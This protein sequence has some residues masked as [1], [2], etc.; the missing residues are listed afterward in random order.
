MITLLSPRLP[1]QKS[2]FLGSGVPY[3]PTELAIFA[4][5]LKEQHEDVFVIDLFGSGVKT[6]EEKEDHYLQGAP[7]TRFIDSDAIRKS[8]AFVLFAISSMSHQE[9]LSITR[10]LKTTANKPLFILEN[11]QAVTAYAIDQ[12]E[13]DYFDA[14]AD[15]LIC[16][17]P[18]WNWPEIRRALF[19]NGS[20]APT[21]VI[22]KSAATPRSPAERKYNKTPTYPIPAWEL[23]PRDGYWSLPYS[24]GPKTKTYLPLFTSRGCP[25]PCDFCVVPET[26]DQRWR[27]RSPEEVV[28]EIEILKNKFGVKDFQIEDLN[29]TVSK[30]RTQAIC[31]L[32]IDKKLDIR[33]Y[34]VSGTKAETIPIEQ[35]EWLAKAGCRYISISPE[36][37]SY[38]V[39]KAIGKPFDYAHGLR[40]I[41]ECHKFGI[42]T[43]ACFVIGHPEEKERDFQASQE[44]LGELVSA[45]LDEVAIFIL[46]P[47]PGSTLFQK[48]KI[49]LDDDNL[50]I[51]FSPKGRKDWVELTKKR[52]KLI[53]TFF[54]RKLARGLPLFFQGFRALLG[55]PRTKMENL[56]RRVGFI[57]WIVLLCKLASNKSKR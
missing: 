41:K 47:L 22:L 37:G 36:S 15:G 33:F 13:K 17:E 14:G 34:I 55:I 25:Y 9:L 26:N 52:S 48:N 46:A 24:H 51:S 1:I 50:L 53:Q 49:Q 43:Q 31:E 7:M 29:P 8:D 44:Y 19:S 57:F 16:G 54:I 6:L 20:E 27:G 21:N 11:S 40:L 4:S 45:G 32:L 23:F 5:F 3:W 2:D 39:M 10:L 18:Y 28:N 42:Y 35:V 12:K 30:A 38:D 56:P